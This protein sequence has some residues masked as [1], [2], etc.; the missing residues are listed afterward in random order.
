MWGGG[1]REITYVWTPTNLLVLEI[2]HTAPVLVYYVLK[3]VICSS[4]KGAGSEAETH[5]WW[6]N[7]DGPKV[8][9][10]LPSRPWTFTSTYKL[11]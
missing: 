6:T 8:R 4:G 7:I 11:D 9:C 10:H 5:V 2:L 3:R 1:C